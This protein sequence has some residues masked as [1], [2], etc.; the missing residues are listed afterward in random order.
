MQSYCES[1]S[2]Q[3]LSS[4]F[5]QRCSEK[6]NLQHWAILEGGKEDIRVLETR[7]LTE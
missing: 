6:G 1:S 4:P 5:L 3:L 7:K 2:R